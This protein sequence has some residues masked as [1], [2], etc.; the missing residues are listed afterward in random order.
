MFLSKDS[1]KGICR[2]WEDIEEEDITDDMPVVVEIREEKAEAGRTS[3]KIRKP[4]KLNWDAGV[5]IPVQL[6]KRKNIEEG[7]NHIMRARAHLDE[8]TGW[9][10]I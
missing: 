10:L 1:M 7:W 8:D 2:E 4:I 5:M 6:S 3:F 9:N